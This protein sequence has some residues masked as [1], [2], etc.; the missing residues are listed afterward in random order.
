MKCSQSHSTNTSCQHLATL[1]FD[2]HV[3]N[4]VRACNFHIRA[5]RHI[6]PLLTLE[7]AKTVAVSIVGSRLDYC[8][9]LLY[10]TTGRNFNGFRTSWH[11]P[12]YKSRRQP[13]HMV[14]YKNCIG[15]LSDTR[16]SSRWRQSLSRRSTVVCRPTNRLE[17]FGRPQLQRPQSVT[18]FASHAFTIAAPVVCNSLSANTRSA[19]SLTCF[20]R[21][22]KS[23]LFATAYAT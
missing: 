12:F 13:V 14:C 2:K 21:R 22:L 7:A 18:A 15:C 20:K 1:S 5:L 8:N 19:D 17:R 11:V 6:R 9:S 10:G 4:V 3:S 23:E 16:F